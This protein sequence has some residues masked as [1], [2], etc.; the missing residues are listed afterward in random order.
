MSNLYLNNEVRILDPTVRSHVDVFRVMLL[1]R[2]SFSIFPELLEAFGAESVIRFMDIFG[3]LTIRVPD[4]NFLE[5][6]SKDADIF[7]TMETWKD[8]KDASDF[9]AVKYDSDIVDIRN[10]Y[11]RIKE[12]LEKYNVHV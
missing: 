5:D 4:R 3:G 9:L 7:H 2:C 8:Q 6:V 12:L 10:R 1:T 11:R